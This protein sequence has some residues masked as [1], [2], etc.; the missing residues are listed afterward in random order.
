MLFKRFNNIFFY[1][2][3]TVLGAEDPDPGIPPQTRDDNF[4]AL[5]AGDPNAVELDPKTRQEYYMAKIAER[6][7]ALEDAADDSVVETPAAPTT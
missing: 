7:G 3:E 5:M 6:I 4:W 1:P 2:D